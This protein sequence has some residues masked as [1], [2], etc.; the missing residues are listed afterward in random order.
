ML[1]FIYR[2]MVSLRSCDEVTA[3]MLATFEEARADASNR[4]MWSYFLFGIRE[5]AGV[6][7]SPGSAMPRSRSWLFLYGCTLVG[8][9][10]GVAASYLLP[11]SYTSEGLLRLE[12]T[13]IPAG[14]STN[15]DGLL[16]PA[17]LDP[18]RQSV[19]SHAKL[20]EVI[21]TFDLYPHIR[22]REPLNAII[23]RMRKAIQIEKTGNFG[24]RVA[25]RYSDFP[26]GANDP[27]KAQ[28]VVQE[29]MARLMDERFRDQSNRIF[30]TTE[31]YKS[32]SSEAAA[33]WENLNRNI[34]VLPPTDPHFERLTLDRELA[35][36]DYESLHQNLAEALVVEDIA[37][38][39]LGS[40]IRI[41]DPASSPEGPD[42]SRTETALY[43]LGFGLMVGIVVCFFRAL[44]RSAAG[45]LTPEPSH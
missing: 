29:L 26:G 43:G 23:E 31:F 28:K 7:G 3:D 38:R 21:I 5:L 35:R 37:S 13:Q 14:L 41:L 34:R 20:T 32:R 10:G 22:A 2:L 19:T 15:L 6:L 39:Q 25:F 44:K 16:G 45:L 1:S 12:P 11:A 36:K 24:I 17:D 40:R 27:Q 9:L 30:Q 33:D 4:G 8:L 42:T 18:L